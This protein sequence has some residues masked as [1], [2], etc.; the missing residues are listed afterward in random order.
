MEFNVTVVVTAEGLF[1]LIEITIGFLVYAKTAAAALPVELQLVVTR[2]VVA[3]DAVAGSAAIIA[4]LSRRHI[5]D[6]K[7]GPGGDQT[8]GREEESGCF[9]EE[10]GERL[11]EYWL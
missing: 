9:D 1:F 5:A 7:D 8:G 2:L 3:V 4:V 11:S 10:H 6:G